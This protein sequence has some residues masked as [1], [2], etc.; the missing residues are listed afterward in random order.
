MKNYGIMFDETGKYLDTIKLPK[1]E[2][3]FK[4]SKG[5]YNIKL[6][7]G[8][9]FERKNF[10]GKKRRYYIY[11]T[12]YGDPFKLDKEK[13]PLMNPEDYHTLLNTEQLKKLNDVNSKKSLSDLLTPKNLIIGGAIILGIYLLST[14]GLT[15]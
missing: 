5:S 6:K 11:N 1:K 15:P 7:E 2:R 4:Y 12:A 8:S 3:K 13:Q 14:G 9:Y 10:M